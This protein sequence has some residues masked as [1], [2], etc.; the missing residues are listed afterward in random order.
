MRAKAKERRKSPDGLTI[1]QMGTIHETI[2]FLE[3]MH[4]ESEPLPR[5]L[6]ERRALATRYVLKACTFGGSPIPGGSA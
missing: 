1:G 2:H 4:N 5:N 6:S 3:W